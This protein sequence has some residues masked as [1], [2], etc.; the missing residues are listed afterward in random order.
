MHGAIG[1][2]LALPYWPAPPP[3]RVGTERHILPNA[4]LRSPMRELCCLLLVGAVAC[5]IDE[6]SPELA[7]R[8]GSDASLTEAS[9][10]ATTADPG[11]DS[12]SM[13]A[14]PGPTLVWFVPQDHSSFGAD[15]ELG[16][17][18]YAFEQG[19]DRSE[20]LRELAAALQLV[21]W[22]SAEALAAEV[23]FDATKPE[24]AQQVI[25]QPSQALSEGDYALRLHPA[26][27]RVR[28]G[29]IGSEQLDGIPTSRFHVGSRPIVTR[30]EL[31][32]KSDTKMKLLVAFSEPVRASASATPSV[33]VRAGDAALPCDQATLLGGDLETLCPWQPATPTVSVR[34]VGFEGLSGGALRT[35]AGSEPSYSF[36]PASL[37][38]LSQ[39]CKVFVPWRAA[40]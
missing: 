36:S 19:R 35:E 18:V 33:E 3:S 9:V 6:D 15:A 7:A 12:E 23:R 16:L 21:R 10:D 25:L 32:S 39:G 31:C 4:R 22:P 28:L 30:I 38:E 24:Y 37:P 5:G 8:D 29:A 26:P 13:G 2:L 40:P 34:F 17:S 14:L 20:I 11:A 27:A 1:M